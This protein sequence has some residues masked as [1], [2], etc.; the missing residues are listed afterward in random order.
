MSKG[1]KITL[2]SVVAVVLALVVAVI[3]LASVSSSFNNYVQPGYNC[4]TVYHQGE[5]KGS[6]VNQVVFDGAEKDYE[7]FKKL[8]CEVEK[9]SKEKVLTSLFQGVYKFKSELIEKSYTSTAINSLVTNS[10]NTFIILHYTT[11][12]TISFGETEVKFY[13]IIMEVSASENLTEATIYFQSENVTSIT[14]MK[15]SYQTTILAKQADLLELISKI[16]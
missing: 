12:Q 14:S 15:S 4:I 3:V 11:E 10:E 16:A 6:F 1:K 2:I 8:S 5:E 9:A 7:T 13:S